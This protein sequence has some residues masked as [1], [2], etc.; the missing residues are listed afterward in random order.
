MQIRRRIFIPLFQSYRRNRN[1]YMRQMQNSLEWSADQAMAAHREKLANTLRY[2]L[3]EIPFYKERVNIQPHTITAENAE[4][5]L[6][7]FPVLT[8]TMVKEHFDELQYSPR[9]ASAFLNRSGGTTGNPT[10]FYLDQESEDWVRGTKRFHVRMTGIEDGEERWVIWGSPEEYQRKTRTTK[11]RIAS[12]LSN[13][14]RING[15]S[16]SEEDLDDLLDRMANRAPSFILAYVDI[17]DRLAARAE[18]TN[19]EMPKTISMMVTAGT[20][21]APIRDRI[22]R[23]FGPA[24]Y[25][26]YGSR[27]FGDLALSCDEKEGLHIVGLSHY[28]EVADEAGNRL[29]DGESGEFL[30][31]SMVNRTMPLVRYAIKDHGSMTR[32]DCECGN[33]WHRILTLDGRKQDLFYAPDGRKISPNAMVH[34]CWAYGMEYATQVQMVQRDEDHIEVHL[35]KTR[36]EKPRDEAFEARMR[37]ELETLFRVSLTIDICW[38]DE[39]AFTPTGKYRMIR[40]AF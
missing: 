33:P 31:T 15:F 36:I 24:L 20:L 39:M 32:E 40:R 4:E 22:E 30:V 25:D 37:W 28:I 6:L 7:A 21:Y 34:F 5:S 1:K 8:S 10:I 26:C 9:T 38:K 16:L 12:W 13:F 23:V 29:P 19:R 27:E 2:C 17:L 14:E 18:E 11:A 3:K 35:K